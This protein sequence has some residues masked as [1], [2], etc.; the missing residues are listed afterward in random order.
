MYNRVSFH[1]AMKLING[2]SRIG[3]IK[4]LYSD[5]VKAFGE[6]DESDEYKISGE[7]VFHN[8]ETN[9]VYTLYDWKSTNLYD[10]FLPGVREF[11]N[12]KTPVTFNIGGYQVNDILNFKMFLKSQIDYAKVGKAFEDVVL[13]SKT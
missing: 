3:E 10:S 6:P 13:N 1:D 7:W 9:E 12:S 2:T 5:I 11:R 8:P 4:L